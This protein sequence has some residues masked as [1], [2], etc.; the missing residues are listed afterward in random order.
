MKTPD[1]IKLGL[2]CCAGGA[3]CEKC[4]YY[5][6]NDAQCAAE[7]NKDAIAYIN[8]LEAAHR[9]EYCESADYDCVELG[10]A[11]KRIAELE[12]IRKLET[13]KKPIFHNMT[14]QERIERICK[15]GITLDDLKR[16][17]DVGYDAGYKVASE[18]TIKACYA[19]FAL[20]LHIYMG[21]GRSAVKT[22]CG[23]WMK[24]SY[25]ALQAMT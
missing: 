8:D 24:L 1:E 17:W 4:P 22:L 20:A 13:E 6:N 3:P 23:L 2:E 16:N 14:K 7:K 5:N 9:T 11:R 18:D 25:I 15:N 10:R 12:C 21:S 19:A